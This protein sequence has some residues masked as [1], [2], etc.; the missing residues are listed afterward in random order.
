MENLKRSVPL[1]ESIG[2]HRNPSAKTAV[3]LSPR[4]DDVVAVDQ[5]GDVIEREAP[6]KTRGIPKYAR[7]L[8]FLNGDSFFCKMRFSEW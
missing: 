7:R 8:G 2:I 5:N 1:S 6:T 3:S 4:R